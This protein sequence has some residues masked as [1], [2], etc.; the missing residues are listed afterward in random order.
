MINRIFIEHCQHLASSIIFAFE[1]H[2]ITNTTDED[3]TEYLYKVAKSIY[4]AC[5]NQIVLNDATRGDK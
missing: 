2:L 5:P 3:Q 1:N 4:A